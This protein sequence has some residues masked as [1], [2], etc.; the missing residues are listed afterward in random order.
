MDALGRVAAA[1]DGV[2]VIGDD[3]ADDAAAA[4]AEVGG[5][6]SCKAMITVG[7]MEFGRLGPGCC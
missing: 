1:D 2:D 6:E 3:D 4:A 5:W 7:E